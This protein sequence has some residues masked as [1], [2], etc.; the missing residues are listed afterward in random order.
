MEDVVEALELARPGSRQMGHIGASLM[1]KHCSQKTT[2][3]R[4]ATSA[5]ARARAS[6]SGARRRW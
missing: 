2:C 6:A 3:S 5:S 4:T 1:L